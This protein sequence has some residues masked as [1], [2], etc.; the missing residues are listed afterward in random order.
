[1]EDNEIR[2]WGA[3]LK[4]AIPAFLSRLRGKERKGFYHYSLSGDVRRDELWGLGNAVFAA[5]ILY[6]LDA[7]TPELR[8]DLSRFILSFQD[9]K[10][11]IWDPYIGRG[12]SLRRLASYARHLDL[13]GFMSE[14]RRDEETKRAETRQAFAALRCLASRPA[15]PFLQ[16]PCA[17]DGIDRYIRALD[18]TRPWGAASHVSHLLFFLRNNWLMFHEHED[19]AA[20][21]I[22]HAIDVA[23]GYQQNDGSWYKPSPRMPLYQKVNG[24]MKMM[25]AF[26][27]A[28]VKEFGKARK[29]ID[30]CLG[31]VNDAHACDNFNI[32]CVLYHCQKL[33]THRREEIE[34]FCRQRLDLYKE[35]YWPEHG[36]FS[37]QKGK[38]NDFYY[39][40]RV[41]A[42]KAE[43]DIHGTVLFLWGVVLVTDILGLRETLGFRIPYT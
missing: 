36:G 22:Q 9:D 24:A 10:G 17:K 30:L 33:T 20:D 11:Y 34:R 16:I 15:A 23:N 31:A 37:F 14:F 12:P 19:D 18:W 2:D 3:A 41:S 40:A 27:A 1:M 42:A 8:A 38:A 5:K 32:V 4:T 39:G 13:K 29:L 21:L 6:M 7:L 28:E 35:F 25:T 26:E 43:P